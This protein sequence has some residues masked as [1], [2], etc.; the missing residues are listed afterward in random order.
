MSRQRRLPFPWTCRKRRPRQL[1]LFTKQAAKRASRMGC[2]NCAQYEREGRP[3]VVGMPE[4]PYCGA[5]WT[6]PT[7]AQWIEFERECEENDAATRREAL[8]VVP[9][10]GRYFGSPEY[11][12]RRKRLDG[13]KK[14][15]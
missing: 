13:P 4:C 7:T 2:E 11:R 12:A 5:P 3:V 15:M 6:K 10:G 8:A 14:R 1:S 9:R